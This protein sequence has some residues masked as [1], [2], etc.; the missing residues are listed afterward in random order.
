MERQTNTGKAVN[1]TD[2]TL[3]FVYNVI[4]SCTFLF[5]ETCLLSRAKEPSLL[6]QIMHVSSHQTQTDAQKEDLNERS[7]REGLVHITLKMRCVFKSSFRKDCWSK[8]G[9]RQPFYLFLFLS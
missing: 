5:Q 7:E 1:Y 2:N 9:E 4:V 3:V 6:K 8:V